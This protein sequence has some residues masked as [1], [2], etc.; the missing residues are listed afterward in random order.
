MKVSFSHTFSIT[1]SEQKY[2]MYQYGWKYLVH[3]IVIC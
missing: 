1:L 3:E 2:R